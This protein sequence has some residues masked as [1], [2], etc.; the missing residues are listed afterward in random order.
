MVSISV[1]VLMIDLHNDKIQISRIH[2]W[3]LIRHAFKSHCFTGIHT[4]LQINR[5]IDL[6]GLRLPIG[7]LPTSR[8]PHFSTCHATLVPLLYLLHETRR[9]LLHTDFDARS[10]TILIVFH[11]FLPIDAQSLTNVLHLD[12]IAEIQLLERHTER[13]V[14]IGRGLLSLPPPAMSAETKV[15]KDIFESPVASALPRALF[16]LFQPLLPVPIVNLLLFFVRE[17][18]VGVSDLG[19]FFGGALFFVFVGVEFEGFGAVGFF[20]FFL[21]GGAADAEYLV[22]VLGGVDEGEDEE[23]GKG[24]EKGG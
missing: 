6:F 23:G 18:F 7:T 21:R 20:D 11:T 13:N 2:T 14:H 4:L 9:D 15:G 19:E 22:E 17:N 5:Q 24:L 1:I 10:L 12:G 16:V 3:L 8:P